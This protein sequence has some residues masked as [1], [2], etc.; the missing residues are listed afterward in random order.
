MSS[1]GRIACGLW[2]T[3]QAMPQT[4]RFQHS[5]VFGR[6]P[7][8]YFKTKAPRGSK[9]NTYALAYR[10]GAS[11]ARQGRHKVAQRGSAGR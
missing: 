10:V 6:N 1:P 3:E 4:N 5:A 8:T 2:L 11:E 7:R 9:A